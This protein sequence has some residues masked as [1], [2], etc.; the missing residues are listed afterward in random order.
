MK[1]SQTAKNRAAIKKLAEFW[2][3]YDLTDLEMNWKKIA[4]PV[5]MR[6]HYNKDA[7]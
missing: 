2:D 4:E 5:F 7:S 3:K 1:K 6:K